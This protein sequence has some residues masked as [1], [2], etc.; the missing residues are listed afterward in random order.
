MDG[1]VHVLVP[2]VVKERVNVPIGSGVTDGD[3][4]DDGESPIAFVAINVKVYAVRFTKPL[5]VIEVAG[6][7]TELVKPPGLDVT[8]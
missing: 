1:A 3:V 4:F 5:I 7:L 6:K 2:T 8:V